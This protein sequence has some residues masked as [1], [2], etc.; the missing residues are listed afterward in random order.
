MDVRAFAKHLRKRY[1]LVCSPQ[2]EQSL[3]R[4]VIVGS[5][6]FLHIYMIC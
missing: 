2:E 6:Y 4:I 5:M 3:K 1:E